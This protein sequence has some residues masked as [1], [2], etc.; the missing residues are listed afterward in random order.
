MLR[1]P[2]AL[3]VLTIGAVVAAPAGPAGAAA[4][5][6]SPTAVGFGGA[7]ATVDADATRTG[8]EVLRAGGNAVDAAVAAAAT[9]GVTEPFSSGIGGGGFFVFYDARHHTV[10]TIDGR[11]MA[12]ASMGVNAFINPATGQPYAF[13]EARVSG[14]SVG[15]PGTPAT[16]AQALRRWGTI[17]FRQALQP[18][19]HVAQH[20]F[21]V[22]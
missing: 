20:G 3:V 22:D 16:W 9:L 5:P 4:P 1:R 8:I 18:A 17:S 14:I 15:V 12:P 13:Q 10:H 6:V 19:I 7:V 2:L 21:L 11:E